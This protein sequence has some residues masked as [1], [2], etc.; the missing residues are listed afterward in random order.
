MLEID[1]AEKV[2]E[3]K[4]WLLDEVAKERDWK[5]FAIVN[6]NNV[7]YSEKNKTVCIVFQCKYTWTLN[8]ALKNVNREIHVVYH[9]DVGKFVSVL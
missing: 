3:A 7:Y 6:T 2:E 8:A 5:D 4:T 1:I 9:F